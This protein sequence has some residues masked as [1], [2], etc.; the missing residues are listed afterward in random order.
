MQGLGTSS[1][2]IEFFSADEEDAKQEAKRL[3]DAH[4][5]ELWDRPGE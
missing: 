5:V 4:A 1:T 3:I 2:R